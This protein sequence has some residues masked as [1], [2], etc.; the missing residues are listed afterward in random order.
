MH[1][2]VSMARWTT[3]VHLIHPRGRPDLPVPGPPQRHNARAQLQPAATRRH[4]HPAPYVLPVSERAITADMALSEWVS[5]GA[6]GN[7]E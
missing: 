3:R 6:E 2:C 4:P 1:E 7:F 5:S